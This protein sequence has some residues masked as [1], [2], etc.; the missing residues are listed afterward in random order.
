MYGSMICR[1]M[2]SLWMTNVLHLITTNMK[3]TTFLTSLSDGANLMLRLIGNELS[4][5]FLVPKA[6]IADNAYDLS[7][8]RYK[9]I[10]YEEVQ[11]D[12]PLKIIADLKAMETEIQSGIEELEGMLK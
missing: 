8:N 10:V 12:P 5:P 6:E 2:D 4:N 3:P 1:Q 9:E 7:I 11:Y